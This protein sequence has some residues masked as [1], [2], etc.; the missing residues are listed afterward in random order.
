MTAQTA[1]RNVA[2]R[3]GDDD[4]YPVA[5]GVTIYEGALVVMAAGFAE[6]GKVGLNL[7]AVGVAMLQANNALGIA[8]AITVKT[9]R[10]TFDFAIDPTDPVTLANVQAQVFITDD[11]TI[12][13]T[14]GTGTKSVAGVLLDISSSGRAVVRVGK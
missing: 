11:N 5:A 7:A 2:Q 8:G 10:G 6:P 4:V 12:C 1:D 3:A 9:R 14:S 13:A